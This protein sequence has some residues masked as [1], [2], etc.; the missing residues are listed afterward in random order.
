MT[1][2]QETA[3]D[4]GAPT[5]IDSEDLTHYLGRQI[6]SLSVQLAMRDLLL[7]RSERDKAA[8]Q[9]RVTEL[10]AMLANPPAPPAEGDGARPQPPAGDEL[11]TTVV[12][13]PPAPA[14]KA[15][16]R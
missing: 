8:L 12:P 15:G 11:P 10:S 16:G 4:P 6:G 7:E 1:E 2:L 5:G 13:T 9:E 3:Q 14:G